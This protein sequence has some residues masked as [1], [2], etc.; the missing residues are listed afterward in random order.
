M[1][2]VYLLGQKHEAQIALKK[3]L[4]EAS[5]VGCIKEIHTDNGGEYLSQAFQ[6]FSI[7]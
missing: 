6:Y 2:F 7:G 1:I 5:P 4:A 3:Y